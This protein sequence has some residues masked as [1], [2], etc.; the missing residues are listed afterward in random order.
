MSRL[1]V[2][3]WVRL[4]VDTSTRE[5][6]VYNIESEQSA[7]LSISEA[8]LIVGALQPV[9]MAELV[10]RVA[11]DVVEEPFII[12]QRLINLIDLGFIELVDGEWVKDASKQALDRRKWNEMGWSAEFD[13]LVSSL[14]LTFFGGDEDGLAQAANTMRR[15]AC[16]APD[17]DRSKRFAGPQ[18]THSLPPIIDLLNDLSSAN[19]WPLDRRIC[20]LASCVVA[21]IKTSPPKWGGAPLFRKLHPSG[22]ARHPTEAY[23]TLSTA[24]GQLLAGHYHIQTLPLELVALPIPFA[25]RDIY[26]LE[27][28]SNRAPFEIFAVLTLTSCFSRNR[29]RYRESRTYRTVHMD[30]GH[31]LSNVETLA[32]ALSL[33]IFV[34]YTWDSDFSETLTGVSSLEEGI[35]ATVFLGDRTKC[36]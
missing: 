28:T 5:A 6:T 8:L 23:L 1:A 7:I 26:E 13:Y 20:A 12:S 25:E 24:V 29:Y 2:S 15:Y 4:E 30:V 31:I 18:L 3:R 34:A 9:Q 16:D 14:N 33:D 19:E 35:L 36:I 21:P 10:T 22:G 11:R 27:P 17:I 32:Q